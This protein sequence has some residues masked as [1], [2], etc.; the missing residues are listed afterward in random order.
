[1][2]RQ[3]FDR[4]LCSIRESQPDPA[5][6]EAA[7][8]RVRARL[9]PAQA[10][11][12]CYGFRADF[13][14][15]RAGRLS[16][17]RRM[18]VEDH[19]HSCAACRNEYSGAGT[20][21]V[22]PPGR[23][24]G[25]Q[26]AKW[27][28]AAAAAATVVW[29]AMPLLDRG[30]A[31]SG[32]RGTVASM[33]G[34]LVLVSGES[35]T[36][37][38]AGAA[39]HQ[40]QEIRTGPDSRAVIRLRDGSLVEMAERSEL[41]LSELW[42]SR[43]VHL[44]QGNVVVEAAPQ[45]RGR[46]EVAT[47]DC[48]V[49][50]HGTIFSVSRGLKGSR[51]SVVE[52]TVAVDRPN[53]GSVLLK[54][55]EQAI[56]HESIGRT[57]VA[58]DIAW[59]TNA[60]KYLE[61]L[62]G[63]DAV[64][65]EISRIPLPG[66]RYTSRLLDRV[67]AGSAIVVALPNLSQ[68]LAEATRILEDHARRSPAL[69]EWWAQAGGEIGPAIEHVREISDYL[70]E[71]VIIAAPFEREP[72]V[73]AEVRRAGLQERLAQLGFKGPIATEGSVVVLGAAAVPPVSQFS[74]TPFGA[75]IMQ[76]YRAG[77]G[78]LFAADMEQIVRGGVSSSNMAGMAGVDNL[79]YLIAESRTNLGSAENT[80]SLIFA[81]AR[82]G[83]ASWLD[84]PGPM[85]TLEFVSPQATFAAA[86]VTRDPRLLLEELLRPAGGQGT[87]F[88][89]EFQRRTNVSLL[90]DVAGALGGEATLAIDGPLLPVPGWKAAVEV[91]SPMRLQAAIEA[92]VAA[93]RTAD[94]AAGF[95]LASETVNNRTY[96]ALSLTQPAPV[97]IHYT[98]VDGYLL[99][100]A[101]RALLD[102]AITNRAAALTLP[103]SAAFRSRMPLDGHNNFSGILYYNLG[104]AVAP[105][106]DQL[107]TSGLLAPEQEAAIASLTANREPSLIYVY[108]ENDRI[109]VGSRSGLLDLGLQ[110]MAGLATGNL[111]QG[112]LPGV[113]LG[114]SQ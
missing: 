100:G 98:Y 87:E 112:M 9:E 72:V 56:T 92:V 26:A 21:P 35:T 36:P 5:A 20:A 53:G 19:L 102:A 93:V 108:G 101:T 83:I 47:A 28:L 79:R 23:G 27:A 71:E 89:T 63:L 42:R 39:I 12:L 22:I 66:L 78:L 113:R 14:A 59:S 62:A 96:Y 18:L 106:A 74:L 10:E 3:E 58:E 50:V 41:S 73:L 55:G 15:Y 76:S 31:P 6:V 109:V 43:T 70:G 13:A 51:I 30:L 85:G 94:P 57:A 48:L 67:P 77:A 38:Q 61:L 95:A 2:N 11:S 7:A 40:G 82:H 34:S 111:T 60:A 33:E 1:M 65:R 17:A 110:A 103:R 86:F 91:Q 81:G 25:R 99:A 44:E 90:D 52:G 64:Q 80:A 75:Q 29:A 32:P 114:G 104:S 69:A 54:P 88:V 84:A 107:K 8:A 68:T 46:L 97:T 4:L 45:G 105:L 49:T 37:L 24:V 16:E